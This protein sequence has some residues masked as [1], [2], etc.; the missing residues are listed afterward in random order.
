MKRILISNGIH[1]SCC[2]KVKSAGFY[3]R[4]SSN[5]HGYQ[6][7]CKA[8]K[9]DQQ[10]KEKSKKQKENPK[11]YEKEKDR[12]LK[13]KYGIT[14]ENFKEMEQMQDGRCAIC[15]GLNIQKNKKGHLFVDHCHRTGKIRKLLCGNCNAAIGYARENI[16]ILERMIAYLNK[17]NKPIKQAA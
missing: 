13:K 8:C 12:S 9:A 16:E 5:W 10:R 15:R 2:K 6:G 3:S 11:F 4:N 17:H 1:C 14:L 7:W